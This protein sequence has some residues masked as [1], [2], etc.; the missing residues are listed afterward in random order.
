MEITLD[1]DITGAKLGHCGPLLV[2]YYGEMTTLEALE[3]LD[4]LQGKLLQQYPMI[5]SFTV[6]P[7]APLTGAPKGL[8]E[9]ASELR[10]K[11]DPKLV[12]SAIVVL[13]SGLGGVVV[14]TFLAG[15]SLTSWGA[16]PMKTFREMKDAETWLRGLP[17]MLPEVKAMD[18]LAE[19]VERF[20]KR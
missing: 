3:S 10:K 7:N 1:V 14:R 5:A 17:K 19:A 16:A 8:N 18:G 6:I 20:G 9:R 12:G 2:A 15:F 11:Y 4:V 13:A